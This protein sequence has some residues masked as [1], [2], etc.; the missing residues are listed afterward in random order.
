MTQEELIVTGFWIDGGTRLN[1]VPSK[2]N[3]TPP[4]Q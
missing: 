3:L 2:V 1:I 4:S